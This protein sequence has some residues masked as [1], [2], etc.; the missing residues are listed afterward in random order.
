[1][2]SKKADNNVI[3]IQWFFIKLN[4]LIRL[5]IAFPDTKL[6]P[7]RSTKALVHFIVRCW[8]FGRLL[9]TANYEEIA[10][11]FIRLWMYFGPIF[12]EGETKR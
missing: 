10:L 4:L 5:P 9:Q 12:A 7:I 1:M 8:S 3:Y 2:N 6:T 11:I